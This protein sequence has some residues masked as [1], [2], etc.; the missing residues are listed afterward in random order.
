MNYKVFIFS[1]GF[2]YGKKQFDFDTFNQI[3]CKCLINVDQIVVSKYN[4]YSFE[5]ENENLIFFCDNKNLNDFIYANISNIGIQKK[6]INDKIAIFNKKGK[7]I[8][9]VPIEIDLKLLE[10]VFIEDKRKSCQFHIFGLKEN[11]IIDKIETLKNDVNDLKY[12]IFVDNLICNLYVSYIGDEN[13]IDSTQVKIATL[14]NQNIFSENDLTLSEIIC[15]LLK[16]KDYKISIWE[17]GT[18]GVVV[19][20]LL[21]Y[22]NSFEGLIKEI[23]FEKA[24]CDDADSL[25]EQAQ[26]FNTFAKS[27]VS[28][29]IHNKKESDMF[30]LQFAICC[31]NEIYLYKNNFK[32]DLKSS[33]SMIKNS[34][35]FNLSKK[36]RQNDIS[37]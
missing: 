29:F 37:F 14:F 10:Q 27:E 25:Y 20:S 6:I 30:V 15:R 2:F 1:T 33:L 12:K 16:L 28:L 26:K 32:S 13:L 5:V 35:L 23:S 31:G 11:E 8:I 9:F 21:Q 36:L 24:I 4:N 17:S 7:N 18:G 22:K 3:C 19:D 34:V